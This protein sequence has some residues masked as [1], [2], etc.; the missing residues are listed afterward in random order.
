MSDSNTITQPAPLRDPDSELTRRRVRG[1]TAVLVI[2]LLLAMAAAVWWWL[3]GRWQASTNDAYVG[4]DMAQVSAQTTGTVKAVAIHAGQ[5]VRR[6][7]LLVELDDSDARIALSQAEAELAKAVRSVRGLTSSA[8]A[9]SAAV[10]QRR[11]DVASARAQLQ[12]AKANLDRTQ[13]DFNRQ[14]DLAAHGFI[15]AQA[16]VN[17]RASLQTVQA[18]REA[19][20]SALAAAEASTGQARAQAQGA[21]AQAGNGV[22]A[23]HPDVALAAAGVRQAVLAVA[24]TRIVSPVDGV[25]E[26]RSVQL[27][28]RVSSGAPVVSVVPLDTI[29]VDANF[30]ETALADLRVGQPAKLTAGAYGSSVAYYGKV[31]G[32]APATG[33]VL[34]LLP[35]QNATG[36]WIKLVQRVPVRIWLDPAEVAAHPPQVGLSMN[37]TVDLHN[38]GGP[39]LGLL[40]RQPQRTPVCDDAAHAPAATVLATAM[41]YVRLWVVIVALGHRPA[42]LHLAL[43][44][45]VLLA[46]SLAVAWWL[47]HRLAPVQPQPAAAKL[48][49]HNP[50]DL[51]V[52]LLF[53]GLFVAFAALTAFVTRNFGATGLHVLSFLVGFTDIDPFVLSLLAG[54]YQVSDA[55]V[56]TAILIASGSN[57]LLKAG[58]AL[59]LSRLRAM[60]P[61]A[62]WLV[63]TLIVSILWSLTV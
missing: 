32:I 13:A 62:A 8:L 15:S 25:A 47:G 60:W 41:M 63:L 56:T 48:G 30:K 44:C 54:H 61:A 57:N 37:V 27:G 26:P 49:P 3:S 34:S 24:R 17:A 4:V 20:A 14:R 22:T 9:A 6:G 18:S 46:G 42:A 35:A 29:W 5:Q 31:A 55:S 2:V 53:A 10:S 36:N 33:S 1:L 11:S 43:P 28:V 7:E 38:Q 21:E 40:P 16:L 19:A 39:R 45:S 51:P 23:A 12:A 52:A 58:Y 59:A 50:L